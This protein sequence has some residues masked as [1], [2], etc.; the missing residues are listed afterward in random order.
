[1]LRRNGFN[2]I[3]GV[4]KG[5]RGRGV[6]VIGLV[7]GRLSGSRSLVGFMASELNRSEQCTVSSDGVRGSLN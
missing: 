2:R 7:L 1:M 5:G 4:N 6:R 3:C